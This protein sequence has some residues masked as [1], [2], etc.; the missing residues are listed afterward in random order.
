MTESQLESF[1]FDTLKIVQ[2]LCQSNE[3]PVPN[4]ERRL[5][6][7]LSKKKEPG[8]PCD[9]HTPQNEEVSTK[10]DFDIGSIFSEVIYILCRVESI[11]E[12]DVPKR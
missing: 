10:R 3:S 11:L 12:K 9:G 1:D 6:A 4:I 2:N 7:S 8:H 5:F